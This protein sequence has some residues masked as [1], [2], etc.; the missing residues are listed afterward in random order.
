[1]Q[2]YY[3]LVSATLV[4]II[5]GPPQTR[6]EKMILTSGRDLLILERAASAATCARAHRVFSFYVSP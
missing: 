3:T 4:A 2:I 6:D 5:N 1:M